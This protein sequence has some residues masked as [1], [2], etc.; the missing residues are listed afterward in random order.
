MY[1]EFL[2][3]VK[4]HCLANGIRIDPAAVPVLTREGE[5][6]LTIHE[7]ATTGGVTLKLGNV[8]LNAPFDDWYC[9]RSEVVLAVDGATGGLEVR[10][11]GRAAPCEA[12]LLPGYLGKTNALGRPVSETTMS[13]G[14]RIRVSP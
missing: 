1:Q 8:Y 12:L 4:I 5:L 2:F 14:D 3:N 9:D 7:Y 13:H 11:A 6:P 10:Y